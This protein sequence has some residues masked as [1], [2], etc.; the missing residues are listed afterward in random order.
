MVNVIVE[1]PDVMSDI[2][3]Y[4]LLDAFLSEAFGNQD[5][6]INTVMQR[7]RDSRRKDNGSF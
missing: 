1:N 4:Q 3:S 2:D 7:V 5:N 6:V